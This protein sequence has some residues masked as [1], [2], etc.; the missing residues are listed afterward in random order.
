[1][2]RLARVRGAVW[3]PER[4]VGEGRERELSGSPDEARGGAREYELSG[5]PDEAR[6]KKGL[7][8]KPG[9]VWNRAFSEFNGELEL[10]AA[11]NKT[12]QRG[13]SI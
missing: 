1:M 6:A 5:S 7:C 9:T 13:R 11:Q 12:E 3:L 2:I 4:G 8:T 10:R